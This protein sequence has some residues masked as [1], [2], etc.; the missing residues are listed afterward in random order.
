MTSA[1]IQTA[2]APFDGLVGAF[3]QLVS[4]HRLS[5]SDLS[6]IAALI[7]QAKKAGR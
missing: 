4:P 6:R 2:I 3:T 7:A 5:A 1:G